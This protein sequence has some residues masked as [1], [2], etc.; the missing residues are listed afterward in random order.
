MELDSAPLAKAW[1]SSG[2]SSP[3]SNILIF[4]LAIDSY[5]GILTKKII[6]NKPVL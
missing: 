2:T 4:A 6:S 5:F 1:N 3:S